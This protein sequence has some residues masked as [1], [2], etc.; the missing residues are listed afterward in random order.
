MHK[1][2]EI[3]YAATFLHDSFGELQVRPGFTKF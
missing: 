1:R 3:S 2:S